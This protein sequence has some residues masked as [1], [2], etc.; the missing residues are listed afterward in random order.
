MDIL[1]PYA[2]PCPLNIEGSLQTAFAEYVP[3]DCRLVTVDGIC[4]NQQKRCRWLIKFVDEKGG[5]L[6]KKLL[7][8]LKESLEVYKPRNTNI[9]IFEPTTEECTYIV[10]YL[11][12]R[13]YCHSILLKKKPKSQIKV[14][15]DDPIIT[16]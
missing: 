3:P 10:E 7:E 11:M 4:P 5:S 8:T 16:D 14:E 6:T 13:C 12:R 15:N 1:P 9:L 2:I